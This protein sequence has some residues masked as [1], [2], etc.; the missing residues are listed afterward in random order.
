MASVVEHSQRIARLTP[1]ADVVACVDRLVRP[2]SPRL[3]ELASGRTLAEDVVAPAAHPPRALA[4]RDGFAVNSD[5]TADASSYAPVVLAQTPIRVDVGDA[6]PGEADAVADVEAVRRRT[7]DWEI[8]SPVAPGEGVLPVAGDAAP[9]EP[10]RLAGQVLRA[11]DVAALAAIGI[12][13]ASLRQPRVRIALAR[14]GAMFQPIRALLSGLAGRDGGTIALAP[15]GLD[16]LESAL[17]G[18]GADLI[19]VIGGT[20]VGERDASV[21]ALAQVGRVEVHGVALTPGDTA[22]FGTVG[23]VPVLLVPGR[24]DAAL[25]VWIALGRRIMARLCQRTDQDEAMSVLSCTLSRK[26]VS[27][28]GMS[29]LV[30]LHRA[31]GGVAPLPSGYLSPSALTQADGYVLVPP[32]SEGYPALAQVEMRMLP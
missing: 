12:C 24:L 10:L 13:K 14:E 2:V 29:E 32:D 22:A 28:L 18:S 23:P 27:N 21:R 25:A 5:A 30:L 26:L 7:K 1:L 9:G 3:A 16:D 6:L 20:G 11:I 19:I 8:L 31:G 4:L 17:V 15:P